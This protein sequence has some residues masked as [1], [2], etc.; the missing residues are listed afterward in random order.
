MTT[1]ASIRVHIKNNHASP[2]TFP[3]TPEG[4]A[5]FTIT[6]ERYEAAAA[7]HP[8]VAARLD[9]VIDW[10]LDNFHDSMGSAEVLV[11]WDF[12]TEDLAAV[13]PNLRWIHII[14]AGVEHLCPM[15]WVPE[16]VTVVNNRGAHGAKGGE[17][18]LMAVLM[19][20]NHMP[21]I[22]D[23][24]RDQRWESLYSTPIAGKTVAVVGVGNIGG[25]AA[26]Q[27]KGAGLRVL[28]V[29]RHGRACEDVDEMYSVDAIDEVLT[30]A[31]FVFVATPLTPET[32]N[33]FDRRRQSLMKPGSGVINV[34]RAGTMDY[35]ALADNLRSGHFSG[36]IL[37][38]FDPEPLPADSPLWNT[39]NLIVTPHV[40]ADDGDAYVSITLEL[41]F[42]NLRRHLANEPL[43]NVV[44]PELG[45]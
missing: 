18:G 13:A 26:R 16:G 32:R 31:D 14:G 45:Y 3:P 43:V 24:Q 25:G 1:A 41:V 38:V 11:T 19:L 4:E 42:E 35:G 10:D 9:V 29:S 5:V 22:I 34:G 28:G 23:N 8:D 20:H 15:D 30:Q 7:R 21:A 17:F 12:P 40:S 2:D 27:L 44:R 36:A 33:L 39:P 37:D 6:R